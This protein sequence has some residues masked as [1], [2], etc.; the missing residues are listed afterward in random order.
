MFPTSRIN[1]ISA[2][3]ATVD[4]EQT[5]IEQY[6]NPATTNPLESETGFSLNTVAQFIEI[7]LKDDLALDTCWLEPGVIDAASTYRV[8]INSTN[9]N[10]TGSSASSIIDSIIANYNNASATIK[11]TK[12]TEVIE[13][14]SIPRLKIQGSTI[15]TVAASIVSGTGTWGKKLA[16][17]QTAKVSFFTKVRR[18]CLV[19]GPEYLEL[20]S[21]GKA[22]RLK[23]GGASSLFVKVYDITGDGTKFS[24]FVFVVRVMVGQTANV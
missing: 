14:V 13:G 4:L 23:T 6:S 24:G 22:T 11:L 16:Q 9:Y 19:D 12:D 7:S 15:S 5:V 20:T 10:G 17:A 21:L 1:E 3:S 18:Y 8:T 2:Q